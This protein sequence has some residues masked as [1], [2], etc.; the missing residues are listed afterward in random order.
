MHVLAKNSPN[1]EPRGILSLATLIRIL[2]LSIGSSQL[3]RWDFRAVVKN[4]KL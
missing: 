4:M 3:D 1:L 2:C